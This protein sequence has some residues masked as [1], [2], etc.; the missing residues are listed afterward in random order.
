MKKNFVG[1]KQYFDDR[2][3]IKQ[4][5]KKYILLEDAVRKHVGHMKLEG[6]R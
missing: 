3:N 4:F 5:S 1:N 2:N 6:T